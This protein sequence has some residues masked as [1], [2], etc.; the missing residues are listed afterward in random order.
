MVS[1]HGIK[2]AVYLISSYFGPTV[3]KVCEC[4]LRR[5]TLALAQI[6]RFTEL[7]R[8]NVN[9]SLLVLIQHNCV[10]AFAIQQDGGFGEAPKILTQYMVLFDNII[11][12]MR[13]PKFMVIVTGE[14]GKGCEEIFEG[15]LQHGRLSINQ[16]VDRHKDMLNQGGVNSTSLDALHENFG[17]LVNARFIERCPAHEPFLAPPEEETPAK[18]RGVKSG[19]LAEES[20][21]EARALAAAAPMESIRFLVESDTLNDVPGEA[22]NENSTSVVL[23]EKRKQDLESDKDVWATNN[24]KEVLW[25]ANFEEFVR[26]LRHKL[27]IANVRARFDDGAGT[28]LSAILEATRSAETKVKTEKSVPLSVDTIFDEVI[29]S[30]EGRSMNVD[31]VRASLEQLGCHNPTIG[32]DETYSIDL[33]Y[34]IELAQNHEV[35]SIVLKK[36]GREAYRIFRLLSA[37][38][39]L[40]ETG[41]ISSTTFVEKKDTIKLLYQLWKDD[42]VHMERICSGVKQPE[43]I[44]WKVNKSSLWEHVLDDMFHAA[45]NLRLR[46]TYEL[47]KEK[48]LLLIP[49]D[50]RHGELGE[51]SNRIRKVRIVLESSLMKLDDALMLFHD[52]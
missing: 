43:F 10:Q 24:K 14:L 37:S 15:L 32:L 29:K 21:L 8:Q 1:Q 33:K 22:S 20:T 30:E 36:Y 13:F 47:E 19:K 41:K 2:L 44:L 35:E 52:F 39:R 7:S 16:I 23:G 38:G 5:G 6:I 11:H 9:N 18:K 34:I 25:R 27:C 48:E 31:R 40:L 26:R 51:R 42:Y 17:E 46:T 49:I 45:L 3:S 50:K 4:L 28:V 12:H